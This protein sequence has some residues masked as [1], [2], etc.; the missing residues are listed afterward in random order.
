MISHPLS[1]P[2]SETL[3]CGVSPLTKK[4]RNAEDTGEKNAERDEQLMQSPECAAV[5]ERGDFRQKHRSYAV[6]QTCT[7]TQL[8]THQRVVA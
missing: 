4:L 1:A 2:L 8:H 6:A 5:V 7:R 3:G